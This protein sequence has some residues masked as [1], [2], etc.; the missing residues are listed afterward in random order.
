MRVIS[1]L[2]GAILFLFALAQYNDPDFLFWGLAYGVP[3]A[4]ALAIAVKPSVLRGSLATGLFL[5]CLGAALAGVYYFWPQADE[6]WRQDIWWQDEAAREGMGLM[7]V[8]AAFAFLA[9]ARL[10]FAQPKQ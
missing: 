9:I 7:I 10:R 5:I 4:W 8:V 2:I 1:G 6:W 3:A